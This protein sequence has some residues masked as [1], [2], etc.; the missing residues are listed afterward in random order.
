M[1]DDELLRSADE[2]ALRQPA[3]LEAQVRRMLREPKSRAL[4]SCL[5]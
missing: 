5:I 2:R 4:V 1:P 3:V